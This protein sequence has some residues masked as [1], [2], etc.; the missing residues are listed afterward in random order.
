ML[1]EAPQPGATALG[2]T[3]PK[4][5]PIHPYQFDLGFTLGQLL[6]HIDNLETH[7]RQ[8]AAR[9]GIKFDDEASHG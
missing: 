3:K 9:R 6:V 1:V 5:Q 4:E 2:S 7:L 8:L